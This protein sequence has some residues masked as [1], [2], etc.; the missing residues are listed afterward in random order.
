MKEMYVGPM[1]NVEWYS[2][3]KWSRDCGP[4]FVTTRHPDEEDYVFDDDIEGCES[5]RLICTCGSDG[6]CTEQDDINAVLIAAAPEMFRII[7]E[8]AYYD[9]NTTDINV[10]MMVRECADKI[11]GELSEFGR[12]W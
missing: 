11:M 10:Y 9:K 8:L 3:R 5:S 7:H 4:V 6:E 2:G 1:K 12:G